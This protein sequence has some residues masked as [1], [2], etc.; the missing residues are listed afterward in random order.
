MA[1]N[2]GTLLME[3]ARIVF[4][5]FAGKEG[6]YNREGDRNFC[7]ILD[8]GVA[9]A[10]AKDGWNIKTLKPREVDGEMSDETPYIQV[11]VGF[12]V[13]PPRIVM[14][15]SRG[16][17]DL[18]EEEIELLDWADVANVDLIIRPYEWVVNGKTGIKA[19]LKSLFVTINEDEL[20][21]KYASLDQVPSTSGRVR[22]DEDAS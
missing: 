12:K 19:Y 1:Q 5:N 13:R 17:T 11:S 18:S 7:V 8:P 2:D 15:T 6:M 4:R 3:D 20:E 10:M 9:E 16:R 14:I 21:L 22:H